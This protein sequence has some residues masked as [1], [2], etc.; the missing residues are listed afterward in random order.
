V[1]E[2]ETNNNP[3]PKTV[4]G[5]EKNETRETTFESIGSRGAMNDIRTTI[6]IVEA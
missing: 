2:E 6:E 5:P 1:V 3:R 4:L